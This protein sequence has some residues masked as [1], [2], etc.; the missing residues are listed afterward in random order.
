MNNTF[1]KILLDF[2]PRFILPLKIQLFE[3]YGIQLNFNLSQIRYLLFSPE[4][5]TFSYSVLN[6]SEIE[7]GIESFFG[8]TIPRNNLVAEFEKIRFS[9]STLPRRIWHSYHSKLRPRLGRHISNYMALRIYMPDMIIESGV[10]NGLGGFV[11]Q[12]GIEVNASKHE[13]CR[14]NYLGIDISRNSGHFLERNEF[15]NLVISN[16]LDELARLSNH[17]SSFKRLMYISDS[18]PGKQV[19]L[20]LDA[21]AQI[22]GS[23]L[24]F[25]YNFGWY[26]TLQTPIGFEEKKRIVLEQ[27]TDHAI[28]QN[29]KSVFIYFRRK[30]S[31]EP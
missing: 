16:S 29:R 8:K 15:L 30:V 22:A 3:K 2:F 7:R 20:E 10:K 14:S 21:A 1:K 12:K 17:K 5:D 9:K 25:I 23:E 31:L 6:A 13:A 11:L 26:E 19:Q 27:Q 4:L 24:L 28:V 18:I